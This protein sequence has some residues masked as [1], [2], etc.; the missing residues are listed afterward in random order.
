MLQFNCLLEVTE[1]F[2]GESV[3]QLTEISETS[4]VNQVC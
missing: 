2:R 1:K 3:W 4:Y